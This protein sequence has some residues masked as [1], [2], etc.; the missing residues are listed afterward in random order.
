MNRYDIAMLGIG[1]FGIGYGVWIAVTKRAQVGFR[2]ISVVTLTGNKAFI[3]GIGYLIAGVILLA[4]FPLSFAKI[5]TLSDE[6]R[7]I[8]SIAGI[9]IILVANIVGLFIAD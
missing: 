7:Q 6:T 5:A 8:L 2:G 1:A 4:P 9:G 3:V